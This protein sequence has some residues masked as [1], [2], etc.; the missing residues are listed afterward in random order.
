M[1]DE[2]SGMILRGRSKKFEKMM[3]NK[4]LGS[5]IYKGCMASIYLNRVLAIVVVI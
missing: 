3:K 5:N 2:Q 4:Y 1:I